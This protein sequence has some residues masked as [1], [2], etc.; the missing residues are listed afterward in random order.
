M[1]L[2]LFFFIGFLGWPSW[3]ESVPVPLSVAPVKAFVDGESV[4]FTTRDNW[5]LAARYQKPQND[6]VFIL[7][8]QVGGK[9][10][11]W[12][13]FATFVS[14]NGYGYLA[15]DFRGH[16]ESLITPDNSTA[17]YKSFGRLGTDNEWNQ[18]ARDV[19]AALDFLRQNGI[20]EKSVAMMGAGLGANIALK[21]SALRKDIPL[22]ILLSPRI[23]FRDVL[24]VNPV[25]VYGERPI[26]FVSS[27]EDAISFRDSQLLVTIARQ[28]TGESRVF[29][30][31]AR[32]SSGTR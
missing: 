6:L 23:N 3:G 16:G 9:K 15:L 31:Q 25:R 26:L 29:F 14:K 22:T 20:E 32:K 18:M 2:F 5:K 11:D 1:R 7:L 28:R 13:P 17:T 21:S 8:H 19:D 10:E 12:I 4:T 27:P 24:T 30:F